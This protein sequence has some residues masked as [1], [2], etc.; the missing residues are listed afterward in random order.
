MPEPTPTADHVAEGRASEEVGRRYVLGV[1]AWGVATAL[2]LGLLAGLP[3]DLVADAGLLS[4]AFTIVPV[5]AV[6]A[7]STRIVPAEQR[8]VRRHV[9]VPY[10]VGLLVAVVLDVV[11]FDHGS[12][13]AMLVGLVPAAPCWLDGLR[14][15]RAGR[16]R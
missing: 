16:S 5:F 11:A 3:R 2:Y 7:V 15:I 1:G 9:A 4:G 12:P 13:P 8:R 14:V 6:V 10:L